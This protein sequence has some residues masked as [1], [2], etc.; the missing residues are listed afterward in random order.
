MYKASAAFHDAV[1]SVS[2]KERI[3]I[4]MD[5][6]ILTNED[7]SMQAGVTITEAVN[8]EEELT[9][10]GCPCATLDT[11]LVNG[12]GL[13]SD[14]AFGEAS[15]SLSVMTEQGTYQQAGANAR[16][17]VRAGT[18]EVVVEGFLQPPYLKV[19]GVIP[20]LQ[21]PFP[22]RAIIVVGASLYCVS[23]DGLLWGAALAGQEAWDGFS[24]YQWDALASR[25]WEVASSA[26]GTL[27]PAKR[28]WV[29]NTPANPD[30]SYAPNAFMRDKAR[31]WA[32]SR[33]GIAYDD[34]ILH[35]CYPDGP[36]EIYEY[37]KL[38]VFL[39]DRP[40]KQRVNLIR[41]TAQ[42]R[43]SRFDTLADTFLGSLQYPTTL[44]NIFAGLCAYVG[45]PAATRAFINSD[46]VFAAPPLQTENATAR[47]VLGWIAEASCS[48]ARMTREGEVELA[49]FAPEPLRLPMA[50]YFETDIAEYQVAAVQTL[51]VAISQSDIGV[52]IG[53]GA[54]AYQIIDNPYLYGEAEAEIRTVAAPI[55][56]RLT[57][58][59][60]FSPISTRAV[61]DWSIQ[62]GDVIEMTFK[63]AT[64]TLPI[65]VQTITWNGCAR[66]R[67][68]CTGT[69]TRPEASGATRR[70][71]AQNRAMHEFEVDIRGVRSQIEDAEGNIASLDYSVRG[72]S[73][74]LENIEGD[75]SSMRLTVD[76]L[77]TK[78]QNT[79]GRVAAMGLTV[80]GLTTRV[81]NAEG[82]VASL[83]VSVNGLTARVQNTEGDIASL[84]LTT[85][86]LQLWVEHNNN[87]ITDVSLYAGRIDARVRNAEGDIAT[88]NM[89]VDQFSLTYVSK[90]GIISSINQTAETI[91]ISASK[92]DL[93]G[94][95]TLT[96]LSSYGET[97]I[98]GSN[99]TTGTVAANRIDV[100]ALY[101]K[102]LDGADGS[103][104]GQL[105]AYSTYFNILEA[106]VP[107]NLT[108]IGN[109]YIEIGSNVRLGYMPGFNDYNIL[110]STQHWSDATTGLGYGNIGAGNYFWNQ[111]KGY[112]LRYVNTCQ[113]VSSIRYK[114][115]VFDLGADDWTGIDGLRP[116]TYAL[117]GGDGHRN[118]GFIAEEVEEVC[119]MLVAY[120]DMGVPD[121][122]LYDRICV[123][124]VAEIKALR[125]RV[126]ALEERKEDHG[127]L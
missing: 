120:N 52:M 32:A 113:S 92:L 93:R 47:E 97:V 103:F 86:S 7:I 30:G 23:A 122:L 25:Q 116:V 50:Q 4:Q 10:G 6:A 117:K 57:A 82:N 91:A 72:L 104:T 51:K 8:F 49:W 31:R 124:L 19:N 70:L 15:V 111:I 106:G 76:S 14:F 102:H 21:P 33:R 26:V 81:Q 28:L 80:D 125:Q 64:Y 71:F 105:T 17:V 121:G 100:D 87:I 37:V 2:P 35:E 90:T 63:D 83:G 1:F 69:S 34:D 41:M 73:L 54:N 43:M 62:A 109:D 67:Y 88:L 85:D 18:R 119:P 55:Y 36:Y 45:V 99:I 38:G 39:F 78:I 123:L 16:A 9:I 29:G 115:D 46:R 107:G 13:L 20:A 75:M 24:A 89:T 56:N 22:V 65:Y 3:L 58:F 126:K 74:G 5:N 59:A 108:H 44:G 11:T 127:T 48:F 95:V 42:D 84:N 112:N 77:D 79:D 98:N 96:N 40:E 94:Y 12:H 114:V 101:V 110:P 60:P 118:L 68:E 27:D 66:V 53:E 61:C